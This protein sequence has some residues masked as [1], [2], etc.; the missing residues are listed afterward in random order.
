[1]KRFIL[2]LTLAALGLP[3][4]FAQ[5]ETGFIGNGYYRIKNCVTERYIYVT[6]NKDYYDKTHDKE[7]F[8]AI[9]LWKDIN[10]AVTS[11][12]S[13]IYIQLISGSNDN[14]SFDLKAQSTAVH[15]LTGYYVNVQKQRDGT[16]EVSASAHGVTKYLSDDE[17]NS[18]ALG[19]MGTGSTG[20]YRKWTVDKI[21]TDHATNYVGI[22]PTI[23]LDGLY[24][25]PYYVSYPFKAASPG[26]NIYYIDRV[27]SHY[28]TL[29]KIEGEVPAGTPVLIECTSNDPS[30]NRLELLASSSAKASDNLL[31]GVYFCNGKRPAE[32]VDAYTKFDAATMRI[33]DVKDGMLVLTDAPQPERVTSLSTGKIFDPEAF[34]YIDVYSDCITGNTSYL[35]ANAETASELL[36]VLSGMGIND[37]KKASAPKLTGVYSL[38]GTQ[39]R[40]TNDLEGLPA[41]IYI[42]GGKKTVIK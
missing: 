35:P 20:D 11:P 33:F 23:E 22:A 32:S 19:M 41:G 39:L 8:Q 14:G 9:Q 37:V 4:T 31:K 26:M 13:V 10:R 38:S 34:K 17:H 28:A 40:Q 7:D 1:M 21:T 30:Q 42:V 5:N 3:Y 36:V 25:Q 2:L 6:D 24:Y 27:V 12:A 18:S 16:Y 29:K 15:A